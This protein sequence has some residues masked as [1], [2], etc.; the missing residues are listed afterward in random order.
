MKRS[1][2]TTLLVVCLTLFGLLMISSSSVVT[3]AR[4]F[5]DKWY[6]LKLQAEWAAIGL[7]GFF[8][9]S[10]YPHTRLEKLALPGLI[11][12]LV[13]L[14]AVLVPGIGT[15]ILGARRWINL[16]LFVLQPAEI[17][18]LSLTLY[19]ASLLKK[20]AGKFL[21]FLV[22]LG[23]CALLVL[24]EPDL[25]TALILC[26]IGIAI[27]FV[28][29]GKLLY[30][31][32]SLPLAGLLIIALVVLSPYRAS[33]LKTFFDY[34]HDPLGASYQIRQALIGL[35]SGGIFGRGLGQSRQK[36]EF[37]P[38]VNTDS[39]FAVIGEELGLTGTLGTLAV[40]LLFVYT[41]LQI[42]KSAKHPFS[43]NLAIGITAWI[44]W[45]SLIN[46]SSLVA[47][48]PLT[49]IPLP[50]VSYGGSSLVVILLASGILVNIANDQ[51]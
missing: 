6:Y 30:L 28:S 25:G 14:L 19:L 15:K 38:E 11:I 48:T 17:T 31:L 26:G 12:S 1:S 41:G 16:G 24:I 27:F 8:F 32:T 40:F 23:A 10:R 13:L 33:R 2:L 35:G 43:A 34:T 9:I 18:K 20:P 5:G 50:F 7:V 44:G 29:G 42:A 39:I 4:D 51:T 21:P 46:I 22:S 37:L 47:L 3:A 36:Y 45:Q 49:G